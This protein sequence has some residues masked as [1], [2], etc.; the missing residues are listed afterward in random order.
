VN[1]LTTTAIGS[2]PL[3]MPLCVEVMALHTA[4]SAGWNMLHACEFI[5]FVY[6]TIK[7]K[8]LSE[9]IWPQWRGTEI[10]ILW[11]QDQHSKCACAIH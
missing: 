10:T 11:V 7:I 9:T 8:K 1:V 6:F 4:I 3:S 2:A 5:K